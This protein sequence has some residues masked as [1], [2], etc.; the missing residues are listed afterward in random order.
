[1]QSVNVKI[2]ATE[3]EVSAVTGVKPNEQVVT[4]GFD[5][6]QNGLKIV[7]RQPAAKSAT[8]DAAQPPAA[9]NAEVKKTG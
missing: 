1:M 3:A 8:P 2:L 4:D 5:K 6:L 9:A 7:I